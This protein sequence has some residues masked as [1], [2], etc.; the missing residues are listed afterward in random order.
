MKLTFFLTLIVILVKVQSIR[1]ITCDIN[2][3]CF[4]YEA[5]EDHCEILIGKNCTPPCDIS[6]C[7]IKVENYVLCERFVC[8]STTTINNNTTATNESEIILKTSIITIIVMLIIITIIIIII[9]MNGYF[10]LKKFFKRVPL[11]TLTACENLAFESIEASVSCNMAN[12]TARINFRNP[13]TEFNE[14]F[15]IENVCGGFYNESILV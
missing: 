13:D 4:L 7:N 15:T 9:A 10:I 14:N 2:K 5:K 6:F 12:Q 1:E 8:F 3:K 11:R